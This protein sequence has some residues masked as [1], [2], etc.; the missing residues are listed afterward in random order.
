M[1]DVRTQRACK[2]NEQQGI[3]VMRG[4]DPNGRH[5]KRAVE[6]LRVPSGVVE[7]DE[8]DLDAALRERGKQREQVTLG[9]ADAA[10][11]VDV[12]DSHR[13]RTR[14]ATRASAALASNARRKSHATR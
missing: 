6:V 12:H 8:Q 11:P 14:S 3:E 7:A 5:V 10:D 9:A 4:A 2:A 13:A 1:H